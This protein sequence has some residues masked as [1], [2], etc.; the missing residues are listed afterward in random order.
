MLLVGVVA[1]MKFPVS[2]SY[3]F[4]QYLVKVDV[5]SSGAHMPCHA[6][7][8]IMSCCSKRVRPGIVQVK[9]KSRAERRASLHASRTD[10][11]TQR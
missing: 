6:N 1:D 4:A 9:G 5:D 11:P 8:P 2:L 7:V 10:T 3:R